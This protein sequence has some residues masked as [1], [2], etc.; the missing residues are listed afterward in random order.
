MFSYYLAAYGHMLVLLSCQI[1]QISFQPYY[2]LYH[3]QEQQTKMLFR[4]SLKQFVVCSWKNIGNSPTNLAWAQEVKTTRY[5]TGALSLSASARIEIKFNAALRNHCANFSPAPDAGGAKCASKRG[6]S[7]ANPD[8]CS[9]SW[10]ETQTPVFGGVRIWF[11]PLYTYLPK[12]A[13]S[14][15]SA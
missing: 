11:S 8:R 15:A 7:D 6:K 1:D 9:C 5:P 13:P 3:Q 10:A 4:A 12:S 14:R 2:T